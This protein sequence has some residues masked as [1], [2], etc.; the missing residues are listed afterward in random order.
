MPF[1]GRAWPINP[2]TLPHRRYA[3]VRPNTTNPK[4]DH[5]IDP[6]W[7]GHA[8]DLHGEVLGEED[9][10]EVALEVNTEPTVGVRVPVRS[11]MP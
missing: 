4:R 6:V 2:G 10:E 1:A 7:I 5:L 11:L 8:F 9:E 3:G